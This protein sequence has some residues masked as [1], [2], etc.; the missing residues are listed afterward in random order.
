ML[1]I[2]YQ[3]K[4][5]INIINVRMLNTSSKFI[6]YFIKNYY[7]NFSVCCPIFREGAAKIIREKLGVQD[8]IETY[9]VDGISGSNHRPILS[10]KQRLGLRETNLLFLIM[11]QPPK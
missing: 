7:I 3:K 10:L 6:A 4:F 1:L 9:S 8:D 11:G 2:T 5:N